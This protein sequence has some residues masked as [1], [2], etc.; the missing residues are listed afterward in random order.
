[1]GVTGDISGPPIETIEES[2]S[3][4]RDRAIYR[5]QVRTTCAL[6]ALPR[7]ALGSVPPSPPIYL[8]GGRR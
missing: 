3:P 6:G 1:M 8:P 4:P 7:S 5:R 2:L